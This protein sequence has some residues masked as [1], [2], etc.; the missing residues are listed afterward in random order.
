MPRRRR[1]SAWRDGASSSELQLISAGGAS[2]NEPEGVLTPELAEI[3]AE[4]RPFSLDQ[5]E[6]EET[7]GSGAFGTVSLVRDRH[8][9]T[10][11]VM[12]TIAKPAD[13]RR[14]A[15]MQNAVLGE[16]DVR[17]HLRRV[18]QPYQL[19]FLGFY[20]N[21]EYWFIATE[22][23]GGYMTLREY[24]REYAPAPA[25]SAAIMDELVRGLRQIH[26]AGVAHNDVTPANIMLDPEALPFRIKYIDFGLAC[27]R[28]VCSQIREKRG[29]PF[30]MAPEIVNATAQ[31]LPFDWQQ[32]QRAD[33]W[34]LGVVLAELINHDLRLGTREVL[35]PGW[36]LNSSFSSFRKHA[37]HHVLALQAMLSVAPADRRLPTAEEQEAQMADET[38]RL[39]AA[40]QGPGE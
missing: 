7:L 32:L 35:E 14:Y 21:A 39:M 36:Q 11:L 6:F 8:A 33:I 5:F 37:P 40:G 29:T 38:R 34:S 1:R 4:A 23:L 30:Y 20:Q 27:Y 28:Q 16:V 13:P 9:G 24:I 18:C 22:F 10:T 25:D 26:Q 31:D 3:R 19:C 2:E 12:K 15:A 17:Q